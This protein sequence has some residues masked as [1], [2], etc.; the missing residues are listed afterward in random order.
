MSQDPQATP[1]FLLGELHTDMKHVLSKL[2]H[3]ERVSTKQDRR[4]YSLENTRSK[5][6]GVVAV[7]CFAWSFL[8]ETI[9]QKLGI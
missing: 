6:L 9:K 4:I 2:D 8:A 7:V 1:E 5:G 3:I